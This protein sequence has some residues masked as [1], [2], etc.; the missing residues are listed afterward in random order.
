MY[1]CYKCFE[2]LGHDSKL[3]DHIKCDETITKQCDKC[4]LLGVY[5]RDIKEETKI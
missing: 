5:V 1:L 2:N 3:W 4:E